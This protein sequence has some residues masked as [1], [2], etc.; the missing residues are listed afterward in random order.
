[1]LARLPGL[2]YTRR[3]P[4]APDLESLAKTY[5]DLWQDQFAS[6]AADPATADAM[7]RLFGAMSSGWNS[8]GGAAGQPAAPGGSDEK[9]APDDNQYRA[10][11]ADGQPRTGGADGTAAAAA[12]LR[13]RSDGVPELLDR[14]AELERRLDALERGAGQAGGGAKGKARKS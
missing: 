7:A 13:N 8:M 14:I 4:K 6:M 3:M 11:G 2:G 9:G 1:M 12:A 5:L 10:G